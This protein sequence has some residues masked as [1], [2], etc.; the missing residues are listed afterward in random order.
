M[1]TIKFINYIVSVIFFVCYFYQFIYVL[2]PF[3]IKDRKS[4]G[5]LK[6][7]R[8]AV[9]ISARNEKDVIGNLIQ[10]INKQDY[11]SEFVDVYVVADNCTDN[12]A[13][14]AKSCG[15]IVYER[16]NKEQVG[17]GYALDYL[18][19]EIAANGKEYDGFFVFDADNVLKSDYIS[20]MNKTFS[21]GY[22]IVTSYRNSKNYDSNWISAG[23]A[24]WYL[25]E[26]KYIQ[27]SRMLLGTSCSISGTGFL[28]KREILEKYDGW[29]FFLLTED[30]QFTACNIANG[31]CIGYAKEAMLY[32]EQPITFKQSWNQRLRWAKG[33]YQVFA[34][35]GMDL[36]RGFVKD[37]NFACFDMFMVVCPA[38]LLTCITMFMNIILCAYQAAVGMDYSDIL[39]LLTVSIANMYLIFFAFGLIT[40]ITEWNKI[41]AKP[42]K[43]I[44]FT[45]TFPIFQATYIPVS[46]VALFKKV[47]WDPIKH[48]QSLSIEDIQLKSTTNI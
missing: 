19:H 5:E 47:K 34:N 28:V 37:K 16:Q 12:T 36:A 21:D 33:F 44:L 23:Y 38:M 15:A 42:W 25:R 27:G 26:S 29:K 39:R 31:E 48:S 11:P 46:I 8:F 1:Q 35:H 10:S 6:M 4:K 43:K 24:L 17:K 40:T 3:I 30:I 9:L 2:V 7:H 18:Y 45:F 32:D 22:K 14:I 20:E 13:E 41:Y